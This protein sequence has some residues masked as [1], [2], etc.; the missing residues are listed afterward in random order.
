MNPEGIWWNERFIRTQYSAP[1]GITVGS[2]YLPFEVFEDKIQIGFVGPYSL[3][4]SDEAVEK[5]ID[6]VWKT[7]CENFN[8][9]EILVRLPPMLFFPKLF[10]LNLNFISKLDGTK[11]YQDLNH[12]LDLDLNFMNCIN[13]N[14]KRELAKSDK[15]GY[16]FQ[17]IDLGTAYDVI[18]RNRVHKNLGMS[19]SLDKLNLLV[20]AFP[21]SIAF[22]GTFH[23]DQIMSASISIRVNSNLAY[24]FMWGHDFNVESSGDSV[25]LLARGLRDFYKGLGVRMLCLGTS[26]TAGV[27]DEGL[28][29]FKLSLGAIETTRPLMLLNQKEKAK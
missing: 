15:L 23:K 4:Y 9:R 7:L 12:H 17:K 14:R 5:E 22:F 13:R 26:S 10:D 21:T 2:T 8:D 27:P 24:V 6:A 11:L 3:A 29:Q 1:Q 19:I 16:K 25:S 18:S 20:D 28:R